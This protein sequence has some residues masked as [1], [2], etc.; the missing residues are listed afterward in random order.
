MQN[1]GCSL[2][3]QKRVFQNRPHLHKNVFFRTVPIY[4]LFAHFEIQAD[5][6]VFA[7]LFFCDGAVHLLHHP[8]D[9]L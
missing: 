6:V 2:Y 1:P 4:T 8:V 7:V 3:Y 5:G 9:V